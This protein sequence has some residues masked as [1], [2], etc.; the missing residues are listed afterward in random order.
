L[1]QHRLFLRRALSAECPQKI[2]LIS[3]G[4]NILTMKLT[5]EILLH[6]NLSLTPDGV[7][8]YC[9]LNIHCT[10]TG[11]FVPANHRTYWAFSCT[12]AIFKEH[13]QQ[14]SWWQKKYIEDTS[15]ETL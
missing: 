11:D 7:F 14:R 12:K 1:Y 8:P 10:A 6:P 4:Y 15:M 9:T 3:T 2:I 13:Q 5:E